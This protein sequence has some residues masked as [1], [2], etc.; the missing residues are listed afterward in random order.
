MKKNK[1]I[2]KSQIRLK[3]GSDNIRGGVN[4]GNVILIA[5]VCL[6]VGFILGATVAI[7][8]TNREP[9]VAISTAESAK[10]RPGDYEEEIQ[11]SR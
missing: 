3:S 6:F 9:K 1:E 2:S 11:L 7:L 10:N 5:V 8:K 4:N